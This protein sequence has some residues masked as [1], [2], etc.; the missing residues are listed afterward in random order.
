MPQGS[1]LGPLLFLLYIND[2]H[3]FSKEF[4]FYLFAD[5]TYANDNLRILELTV[6]NELDKVGESLNAN[7]L[8][9]NV[10]KSNY[11]IFSFA[12]KNYAFYSSN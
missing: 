8:T 5:D 4:T 7:K 12:P 3:K 10:N 6:N 9:L 1:V 2:I 11:V